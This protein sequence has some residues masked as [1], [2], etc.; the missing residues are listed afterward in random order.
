MQPALSG[1]HNDMS[2][3]AAD[4]DPANAYRDQFAR[5]ASSEYRPRQRNA[6]HGADATSILC[7][8]DGRGEGDHAPADQA[9]V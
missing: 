4:G 9:S 5:R 1:V 8:P 7:L 3:L 2:G 6:E